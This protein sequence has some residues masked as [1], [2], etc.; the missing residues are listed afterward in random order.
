[1]ADPTKP[2]CPGDDSIYESGTLRDR[3]GQWTFV[4]DL[5]QTPKESSHFK[6]VYKGVFEQDGIPSVPARALEYDSNSVVLFAQECANLK[7]LSSRGV[8]PRLLAVTEASLSGGRRKLPVL[9]ER[10][11]GSSLI[12]LLGGKEGGDGAS[13][14][15]VL[16]APG[17]AERALE[18]AKVLFDVRL[19]LHNAHRV[20]LYHRDLRCEN[21]C[22]RRF[23]PLPQ[24][25]RAT[26][27]DFDMGSL[28]GAGT[29][30]NRAP[31]Y[32]TLFRELPSY[33]A[34]KPQTWNPSPLELDMGY[35]AVL[36]YHL[37]CGEACLNGWRHTTDGLS[38]FLEYL[39]NNVTYF[40]Y[41]NADAKP[42]A[43]RLDA[44]LD[45]SD[46]ATITG[47]IAVDRN[48]FPSSQLLAFAQTFHKPFFDREDMQMCSNSPEAKLSAMVEQI[49]R[50]K[51]ES[52]K[53]LRRSQ[54][55]PVV[56]EN[57]EDQPLDLQRSN[58]AQ[59]EHI[60]TKVAAL[61][62][63]LAQK[64]DCDPGLVV[65]ALTDE[66]VE[67]LARMEHDRF[68]EERVA[69]G[70]AL[71]ATAEGSDP[72]KKTSPF[73]VPYDELDYDIQ[74]YDRDAVR[75]MIPLLDQAGLAIV[76]QR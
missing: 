50:A 23:G 21:V 62:Y 37:E 5:R 40:G 1:M 6:R 41:S 22:V 7:F 72:Q 28:V 69:A 26:I 70:W 68:V 47:L 14:M 12:S 25:V 52:Y 54:G 24:D 29:P 74:E 32:S 10:D 27:I 64:G 53:D 2:F 30:K 67:V 56:Y 38:Q 31:L 45:L 42:Y 13:P 71:D 17:T 9:I 73:L 76:R 63:G 3:E 55:K 51:F 39:R 61:G 59:A 20:G 57:M 33:I 43:R 8:G 46:L 19:Q 36:Q 4:Y 16:H 15:P 60:P 75:Q 34:Q 58:F 49:A 35:L 44:A 66:Q 65:T 18:N 48:A 11:A